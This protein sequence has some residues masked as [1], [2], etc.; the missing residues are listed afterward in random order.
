MVRLDEETAEQLTDFRFN[1][2]V[3]TESEAVRLLLRAGLDAVKAQSA[4]A[5]GGNDR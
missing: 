2:R 3:A 1:H 4:A 5:A